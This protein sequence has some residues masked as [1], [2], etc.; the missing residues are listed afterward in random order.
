MK[1]KYIL[2]FEQPLKD[3]EER[4]YNLKQSSANTGVDAAS[5]IKMEYELIE[6]RSEI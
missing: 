2:D 4:I 3:I 6:M 1:T 5:T